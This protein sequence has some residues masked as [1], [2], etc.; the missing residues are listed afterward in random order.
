MKDFLSV[1]PSVNDKLLIN[2][3]LCRIPELSPW[4]KDTLHP[5]KIP[6]P[7]EDCGESYFHWSYRD[8]NVIIVC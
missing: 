4:E 6:E 8:G 1:D 3:S 7:M 5:A 2:T